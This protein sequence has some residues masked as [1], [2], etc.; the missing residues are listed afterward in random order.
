M[1]SSSSEQPR[2]W[3]GRMVLPP[4]SAQL[5]NH[6]DLSF[7]DLMHAMEENTDK[8]ALALG[9]S[10]TMTAQK[11]RFLSGGH[12]GHGDDDDSMSC[13][14]MQFPCWHRCMNLTMGEN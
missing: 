1:S 11:Q 4:R 13:G 14:H 6:K 12:G 2:V 9:C 3:Y 10:S 8:E 5:P 7:G